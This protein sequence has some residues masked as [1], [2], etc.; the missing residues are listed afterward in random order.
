MNSIDTESDPAVEQVHMTIGFGFALLAH[1]FSTVDVVQKECGQ[2]KSS[3]SVSEHLA[4]SQS[5]SFTQDLTS[6][7]CT[8]DAFPT[9]GGPNGALG[10]LPVSE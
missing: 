10:E 5:Y 3:A 9:A 8:R 2:G 1:G 6:S 4:V 7:L